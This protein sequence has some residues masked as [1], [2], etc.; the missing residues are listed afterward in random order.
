MQKH[1]YMVG[2]TTFQHYSKLLS[3]QHR[4]DGS[5]DYQDMYLL[6]VGQSPNLS[7]TYYDLT[8][9]TMVYGPTTNLTYS[10]L[11]VNKKG[12][13]YRTYTVTDGYF[14][15]LTFRIV[16]K[17]GDPTESDRTPLE[18][19]RYHYNTTWDDQLMSY[20]DI[21]YVGGVP[22]V[23][24]S[25]QAYIYDAQGNPIQITNFI[26]DGVVYHHA[27]LSWSGRA[28]SEIKIYTAGSSV[29]I[30]V[31]TYRYNDQ[32]Y[33]TSKTIDRGNMGTQT[34]AYTLIGSNV[35]HETDG[36]YGLTYT[37]DVDQNIIGFT[38]DPDVNGSGDEEDYFFLHNR[39]GD[40][41]HILDSEGN[42]VVHYAYDAYGKI[43]KTDVTSGYEA[44][45]E[46]NPYT[47]RSYRYDREIGWYYLNSRYY[48]PEIK[49]FISSDGLLG[50]M[51]DILSTN[52]YA[53]CANNPVMYI[54][55]SGESF[56]FALGIGFL[57][58]AIIGGGFETASQIND[59]GFTLED[60]DWGQ[61]GLSALGGG[62][63]GMISAIPIGG[64][65]VLSYLA[66][67]GIG[68][69]ASVSGGLISGSVSFS[70]P[71]T[72]ILS[73]VIGGVANVL[74]RGISSKINK[75][76]ADKAKNTLQNSFAFSNM[77]LSDLV[78][79]GLSNNGL[80]PAY[81]KLAN[82]AARLVAYS[83]GAF[84]KSIVYS[85]INSSLSSLFS[86]WY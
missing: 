57:L 52:M 77:K 22:Q 34:T 9:E 74:A 59:N 83:N 27:D 48:D 13:Y 3:E 61:I 8:N 70:E 26:F 25:L 85:S 28:L 86:G 72:I 43:I 20:G 71:S 42:T 36:T 19:I 38:Y 45:A 18:H 53:Y 40:V 29:P 24:I 4:N 67:F 31:I 62:I 46:L 58:G 84:T 69:L 17:V 47:Y 41:T 55:P 5:N 63:A 78:G 35:I 49:R 79:T 66:S 14:Y 32:G 30:G 54:D 6:Q 82:E 51:G 21:N 33:R 60:W 56:I 37:Y 65:G 7:F 15:N 64:T 75:M 39:M 11:N 23:E 80:N 76:V 10:N 44:I 81:L 16:F 50:Q 12:Y 1:F 68:G 73:F 2:M